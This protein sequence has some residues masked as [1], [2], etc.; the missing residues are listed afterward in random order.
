MF[1]LCDLRR[2]QAGTRQTR[3]RAEKLAVTASGGSCW[4]PPEERG[5]ASLR[6]TTPPRSACLRPEVEE[7]H[8]GR[9]LAA[10]IIRNLCPP[11]RPSVNILDRRLA[12]L[13]GISTG[14]LTGRLNER[15]DRW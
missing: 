15:F 3:M 13:T 2:E 4:A 5:T 10:S 6:Q 12:L 1:G 11:V 8:I 14:L 7:H 9:V